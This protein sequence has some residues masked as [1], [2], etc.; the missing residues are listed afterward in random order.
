LNVTFLSEFHRL[1]PTLTAAT[2][3]AA[4]LA[5]FDYQAHHCAIYAAW[6]RAL[7]RDPA[8]V[9]R[10]AD[11]PFLPISF[12]K[13]HHVQTG[14]W[15]PSEIF[16]SSATTGLSRS[17]HLVRDGGHYRTHAARI[18]ETT[19]GPLTDFTFCALL[20]SY[21]EQGASS[22][23]AMVDYFAQA[24][25]QGTDP[26]FLHDYSGLLENLERAAELGRTPVLMG[27]SYALL[28]LV[29][30]RGPL[31]LPPGTLVMET[32][33]MKG[34]RREMIREEL[35]AELKVSLGVPQIHSE[36][37]M[38]ELLSQAYAPANGLFLETPWLRVLLR[39]PEDPLDVSAERISG[40]LNLIDLA[41]FDTCAFLETQDLARRHPQNGTFEVLGRF[42]AADVR[43]CNLL[44]AAG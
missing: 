24:S 41:N 10:V 27:V 6:L 26:F 29:E 13:T 17:R 34:R 40:G 43:G 32:G 37:G 25:E 12:F 4:A 18:W 33:G 22:L 11:I 21:L 1:L 30:A 7:R 20:P 36:Y 31:T 2:V 19:Y 38:T 3:E 15:A 39:D 44:V 42:D 28:D 8:T 35:H 9:L 14:A 16:L 23:V 5:L